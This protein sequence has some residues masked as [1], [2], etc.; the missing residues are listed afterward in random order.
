MPRTFVFQ[1]T[2]PSVLDKDEDAAA[3]EEGTRS[4][5]NMENMEIAG[6]NSDSD[7]SNG[8]NSPP[9]PPSKAKAMSNWIRN[10]F[11]TSLHDVKQKLAQS[12]T[13]PIGRSSSGSGDDKEE[14]SSSSSTESSSPARPKQRRSSSF[15][16]LSGI[17]VEIESSTDRDDCLYRKRYLD[18]IWF[19]HKKQIILAVAFLFVWLL[20][21]LIGACGS[22]QCRSSSS[23]QIAAIQ[24]VG[25]SCS[26]TGLDDSSSQGSTVLGNNNS[27]DNNVP[28]YDEAPTLTNKPPSKPSN[29]EDELVATPIITNQTNLFGP[30]RHAL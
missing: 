22:G 9:P 25:T 14:A 15:Q 23:S 30:Q 11:Q 3:V 8:N 27:N 18:T 1:T 4:N 13:D 19:L 7:D 17:E 6:G 28:Q 26:G 24:S 12:M 2:L 21:I 5:N 29:N 10:K 16:N 20:G